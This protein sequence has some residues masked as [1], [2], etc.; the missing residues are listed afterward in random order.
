MTKVRCG[1]QRL[2]SNSLV[3]LSTKH[4]LDDEEDRLFGVY[5]AS[6]AKEHVAA[7]K[8]LNWPHSLS[9]PAYMKLL[10]DLRA[11]RMESNEEM[12]AI[13]AHHMKMRDESTR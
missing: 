12:L 3:T 8:L 9:H 5:E 1:Q 7:S 6:S 2:A 13:A 10:G 11:I 4:S